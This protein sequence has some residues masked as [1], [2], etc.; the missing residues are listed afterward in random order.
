MVVWMIVEAKMLIL[1]AAL[2]V[3]SY[4]DVKTREIEDRVWL[5]SGAAGAVLTVAEILATPGYPLAAAG[6]SALLTAVIAVGVFYLGLYGG[7][8]AKALLVA[9]ATLPLS[10]WIGS[11]YEVWRQGSSF[12]NPFFPLTLLGNALLLSLLLVPS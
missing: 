1:G 5:V 2:A 3:A 7:A 9:G 4:Q 8:D 10:S 11:A 12:A 6:L